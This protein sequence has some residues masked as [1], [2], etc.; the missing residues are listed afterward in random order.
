MVLLAAGL[1]TRAFRLTW[2]P[3]LRLF[4]LDLPDVLAFKEHVLAG[5]GALPRCGR[6][7][8]P[9]DLQAEWPAALTTA[10]FDPTAPTAWLAEGL[11]IYLTAHDATQLLARVDELS[12][13]GSQLSFEHGTIA[14]SSL[15]AQAHAVPAMDQYTQLWKGGL[16]PAG[17]DWLTRHGWQVQTHDRVDLAASY[18]SHHIRP[19]QR[20]LPHRDPGTV[21]AAQVVAGNAAFPAATTARRSDDQQRRPPRHP[22]LVRI[23]C[24]TDR[25]GPVVTALH[26]SGAV[27]APTFAHAAE[28]FLAAH[29]RAGAWSPGTVVKYRQTLTGLAAKLRAGPVERSVAALTPRPGRRR[30]RRRSPTPT[31][32]WPQPP[33]P[34]TWP[35]CARPS[36]GGAPSAGWSG[37]PPA[38]GPGPRSAAMTAEH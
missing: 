12:A 15:L 18:G 9:I 33:A 2:P 25:E 37:T 10:G 28:A 22:P 13:E 23:S 8:L 20:R 5:Q 17:P 7:I 31:A 30:W 27:S 35:R 4:E 32:R 24:D 34:G 1:D 3:G 16:G 29:T 19:G 11:L 6:T 38:A 14:D 21:V 26:S 36:T